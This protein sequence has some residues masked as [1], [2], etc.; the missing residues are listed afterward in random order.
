MNRPTATSTASDCATPARPGLVPTTVE[1]AVQPDHQTADHILDKP[2][3]FERTERRVNVVTGR[4]NSMRDRYK[5]TRASVRTIRY[6]GWASTPIEPHLV[7][8]VAARA[9][10]EATVVIESAPDSTAEQLPSVAVV[11]CVWNRI[12][13][14]TNL[15]RGLAESKGVRADVY[16]WNNSADA[17]A[18]LTEDLLS[19]PDA[20]PRV[21]LATSE[22]NIGGFGRFH[23]ARSL[24]KD[25][26][27]VVFIDDDQ[28]VDPF[29]LKALVD[30]WMPH[31]LR[32]VW[33]YK[34]GNRFDYWYRTQVGPGDRAM[35]AGTGGMV[36]DS[37]IF[38]DEGLFDC[39]PRYWFIEDLWLSHYAETVRG[40]PIFRS[41]AEI[42]M[43]LDGK[44]QYHSLVHAKNEFYRELNKDGRWFDMSR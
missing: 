5:Q 33:A 32:S 13:R 27:S 34:F 8:E 1:A 38:C 22:L 26:R 21:T 6:G 3:S 36:A 28:L 4:K 20:L 9:L 18:G 17:A 16:L 19:C 2:R 12:D 25:Y 24:A 23:W 37:T 42:G 14:T 30:E 44:D 10:S 31:T 15:L 11:M 29:S 7:A 39:P 43:L 35:Y 41:E 40:W